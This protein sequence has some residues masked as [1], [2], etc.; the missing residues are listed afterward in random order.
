MHQAATG[1]AAAPGT[2]AWVT[3]HGEQQVRAGDDGLSTSHGDSLLE[4]LIQHINPVH[5]L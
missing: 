2:G 1:L 4:R 5:L 3:H